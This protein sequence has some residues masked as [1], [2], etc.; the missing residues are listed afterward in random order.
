MNKL[1]SFWFKKTGNKELVQWLMVIV[2]LM[3]SFSLSAQVTQSKHRVMN[4]KYIHGG[5]FVHISSGDTITLAGKVKTTRDTVEAKRGMLS[6][7][8]GVTGWKSITNGFVD[9]YV[10][11]HKTGPFIFPIGQKID[12]VI[13]YRPAAVSA[14]A[15]TA[16]TDAAYYNSIHAPYSTTALGNGISA[17][18]DELWIIQ[19]ATPTQ[20]ILSWNDNI[21]TSV[22]DT[23]SRLCIV[24]WDRGT[25]KWEEITSTV[26]PT[27]T[28]FGVASTLTTKGS[29][30]TTKS[31]ITPN[32]YAAYTLGIKTCITITKHPSTDI[33][34]KC[35]NTG[36]FA[37]LSITASSGSPISYQ[38]Y[39][40]A[41]G[42]YTDGVLISGADTSSYAPPSTPLGDLYYYCVVSTSCGSDTSNVSGKHTVNDIPVIGINNLTGKNVL[43]LATATGETVLNLPATTEI[44]LIATSTIGGTNFVWSNDSTTATN[45][46]T[47]GGRYTVIGTDGHGCSNNAS[48]DIYVTLI[49]TVFPFVKWDI[50]AFDELFK[51]TVNLKDTMTPAV[52]DVTFLDALI[53]APA[54]KSTNPIYHEGKVLLEKTPH[55]AG[56]V[57]ALSNYPGNGIEWQS[58][59]G[60]SVAPRLVTFNELTTGNP[61]P[62]VHQGTTVGVFTLPALPGNYILELKRDGYVTRWANITVS[63]LAMQPLGHREI[64]AGDVVQTHVIDAAD[65]AA[66]KGKIGANYENSSSGYE[67]KYDLNSDGKIDQLDYNIVIKFFDNKKSKNFKYSHYTET[68]LWLQTLGFTF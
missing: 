50:P 42:T 12:G 52:P 18:R 44:K 8:T 6:F 25:K 13:Y 41:T 2:L 53:V 49:G 54:L 57:G 61:S 56:M 28:I 1:N 22:L 4:N 68:K 10:R 66:I 38:W 45:T 67:A 11:T 39:S 51:I 59:L 31:D 20:I 63:P 60:L 58:A 47:T 23:T 40:S 33:V 62:I 34:D 48:I 36:N 43:G 55:N 27:S 64:V 21:A 16:P 14:A 3:G 17:V 26:E 24:G 7:A 65:A 37:P 29:I 35:L 19:G 30:A 46:V 32:R 5:G 15:D 9:G